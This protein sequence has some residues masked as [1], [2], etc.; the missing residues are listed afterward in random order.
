[1]AR[2]VLLVAFGVVVGVIGGA[3]LSIHAFD[4]GNTADATVS[5]TAEAAVEEPTPPPDP[6]P[7]YGVFDRLAACESTGNWRANTGNGYFGGLQEDMPF[8]RNH[9]GLAYAARPDLASR[10]AQI[11]VA[12]RGLAAQGWGAWPVCSRKLGLR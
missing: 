12:E 6:E 4:E 11:A 3:A 8:W 1:M 5:D 2:N 7:S 9:G 10:A